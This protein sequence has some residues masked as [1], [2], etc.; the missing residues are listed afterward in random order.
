MFGCFSV[1]GVEKSGASCE[2]MLETF[3]LTA[4]ISQRGA[5]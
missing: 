4:G 1:C 3:C 5:E 2:K